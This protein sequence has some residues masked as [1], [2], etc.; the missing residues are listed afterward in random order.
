[1]VVAAPGDGFPFHPP[2]FTQQTYART[3]DSS[4]GAALLASFIGSGT[5]DLPITAAAFS[6]FYSDSG[7][8][9]GAVLTKASA[10]VTVQ[11]LYTAAATIPEPYSAFLLALGIT[12]VFLTVR[13]CR[14]AAHPAGSDRA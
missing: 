1:L 3:L 2:T 14:R 11:Y 13:F 9:G 12:G 5:V 6:S 4:G 7:N 10:T 8:G